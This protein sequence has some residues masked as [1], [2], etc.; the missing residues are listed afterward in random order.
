MKLSVHP[1]PSQS[2]RRQ[3]LPWNNQLS[4]NRILRCDQSLEIHGHMS[5]IY[6]CLSITTQIET[7]LEPEGRNAIQLLRHEPCLY[8]RLLNKGRDAARRRLDLIERGHDV[9]KFTGLSIRD[10]THIMKKRMIGVSRLK[11]IT[12]SVILL[13]R[14]DHDASIIICMTCLLQALHK[15]LNRGHFVFFVLA[16]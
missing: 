9:W 14:H 7:I 1:T 8:G 6:T 2:S 5:D 11:L 16:L 10:C 15:I 3:N 12:Q 4:T 13:I